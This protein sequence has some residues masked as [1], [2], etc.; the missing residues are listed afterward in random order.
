MTLDNLKNPPGGAKPHW[1]RTIALWGLTETA[2]AELLS[3]FNLQYPQ[4]KLGIQGQFPDLQIKLSAGEAACDHP[5]KLLA[6]AVRWV[7][8][9]MG[10][11]VYSDTGRS[12]E[13]VVGKLLKERH[14][15]LAVA[16]SCT[17]GLIAHLLTD[18]PGSSDY[19]LFSA[20]TYA[21]Q[22]KMNVLNVKAETL[23]RYGAVSDQTAGEMA[24]GAKNIVGATYG[25]ATSG[26]AGPGGGTD[27]KP[28]GTVSIG[29][30]TPTA[31]SAH[32]FI[33]SDHPRQT[34]KRLFAITALD[35]LR[36]ALLN[37]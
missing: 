30:A 21:N 18:V 32:R 1:L 22:A 10:N 24:L 37:F 13:Q 20:V 7:C 33:F 5:Q 36:Q 8:R 16:E 15:T 23:D 26:I 19:F 28:V 25:L 11:A 29:L 6:E 3:G 9:K 34:N 12:M 17:G 35:F 14:A 31:V 4:F 27:E 2:A